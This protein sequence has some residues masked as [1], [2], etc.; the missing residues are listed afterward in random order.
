MSVQTVGP[1]NLYGDDAWSQT[2][3]ITDGGHPVVFA[4]H[5]TWLCQVVGRR[6]NAD[7]RVN[8]QVTLGNAGRLTVSLSSSQVRGWAPTALD[9]RS[10]RNGEVRTWLHARLKHRPAVTQVDWS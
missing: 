3:T 4:N 8:A 7:F 9:V 6:D 1:F 2:F 10:V 5:G